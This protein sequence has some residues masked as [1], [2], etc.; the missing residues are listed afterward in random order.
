MYRP[1]KVGTYFRPYFKVAAVVAL[2]TSTHPSIRIGTEVKW[3]E[4]ELHNCEKVKT[5]HP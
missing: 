3:G 5:H 4:R 2:V 1:G